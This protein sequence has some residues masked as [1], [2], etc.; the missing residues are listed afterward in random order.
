MKKAIIV[1]VSDNG[2]IGVKNDLPWH[3]PKD[4]KFFKET[5]QGHAIITGR[6]NYESIP[7]KYRPLPGRFN[8]LL[9]KQEGYSVPDLVYKAQSMAD[10]FDS[11][12]KADHDYAF[13]IGG[14]EIYRE[15]LNHDID[16]VYLT[17]V[18]AE[19]EGDVTFP[20]LDPSKWQLV[21]ETA[22]EADEKHKHA[23]TFQKYEA[24]RPVI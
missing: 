5:T 9:T 20:E 24:I 17:R 18:H 13:V 8:I 7:E 21:S 2:V 23:F 16:E 19:V 14:G 22:F 6:K 12:Y 15:A 3:L 4:M 1:A 10:A 11:A